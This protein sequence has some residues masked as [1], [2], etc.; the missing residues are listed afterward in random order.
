MKT[1]NI[2]LENC[3]GIKKFDHKL[4]FS[5]KNIVAI[6]AQNGV[7]KSSFA[8]VFDDIINKKDSSDRIFG[9][10]QSVRNITDEN[11][12]E[13]ASQEIF[14]IEPYDQEYQSQNVSTLLVNKELRKEYE[15]IYEEINNKKQALIKNL[16]ENS[17][18]KKEDQIEENL[19]QD[20]SN[21]KEFFNALN[22]V[23]GKVNSYVEN[24]KGFEKIE[25]TS[26]FNDK[27]IELLKDPNII[28]KLEEY[29]NVYDNLLDSST[30][31][32]KG[33][34]NHNNASDIA[35]KLKENGFFKA[36][37]S[38][39][40]NINGGR[41]EV[42]TEVE[43]EE[44]IKSEKDNIITD[45]GL[46]QAFEGLDKS[47]TK[48]QATKNFRDYIEA[49]KDILPELKEIKAFKKKLWISYLFQY[50]KDYQD[51]LE[52]YKKSKVEIEKIA[53]SADKQSTKWKEVINEFNERYS[54]PFKLRIENQKDVIL[55]DAI[56]SVQ[57]DFEDDNG[58]V[59]VKKG[60]L[61]SVLSQ[62]EKR[63]LY[64][65]NII[66]EV[67][68]Q[69]EANQNTLFIIDDIA[70][71]FDYKNKYAIIEYLKDISDNSGFNVIILTHNFDFYRNTSSRLGVVRENRFHAVK[72]KDKIVLEKEKYLNNPFTEWKKFDT[73][74]HKI[75]AI[76]FVRELA[77]F[78]GHSCVFKKLT[79]VLHQKDNTSTITMD[80]VSEIFL[81]ILKLDKTTKEKFSS[82]EKVEQQIYNLS[83]SICKKVEEKSELEEKVILSM[84]IRLKAERFL[85]D[86]IDDP[87]FVKGLKE[88]QT[89]ELS[90]EYKK[91]FS[92][93]SKNINIIDRVNLMT[94][95]NIHINSF[96]YEPILDMS[97]EHLKRLY[98]D[99]SNLLK[100][101]TPA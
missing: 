26:I 21:K 65:L 42:S 33:V 28:N 9:D 97:I 44:V 101:K 19:S 81:K 32:K 55:S 52:L 98:L 34:F 74:E 85:I 95:E 78:S 75:A 11:S 53:G 37:H 88:N 83:D 24:P 77:G 38:V 5:K 76:P 1:L 69:Q 46:R 72:Y 41:K 30:F 35:K 92:N 10:R 84:A 31:F 20:I 45:T 49:N 61:L 58:K 18:F 56:P 13:I 25:Y 17:G 50:K 63:A 14:V 91:K 2:K 48:N 89:R 57:F 67:K 86:K 99:T 23:E 59:S 43:L 90:E 3:Y 54:V 16:K 40:I 27:S 60:L 7:M 71:S 93:E 15:E 22:S 82:S 68:A 39:N 6:Y 8:K 100:I 64:I 87:E 66:F 36:K 12:K 96:M 62:G 29:I 79:C 51:L 80:D 94:P 47:L 73:E 70:D 4:D